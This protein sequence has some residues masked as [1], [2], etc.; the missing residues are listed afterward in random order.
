M[1]IVKPMDVLSS[2]MPSSA[3][4]LGHLVH[5]PSLPVAV[6]LPQAVCHTLELSPSLLLFCEFQAAIA[7]G[8][9]LSAEVACCVIEDADACVSHADRQRDQA[10]ARKMYAPSSTSATPRPPSRVMDD[11][12]DEGIT[13]SHL[14][15][16]HYRAPEMQAP[17]MVD[18]QNSQ[19]HLPSTVSNGFAKASAEPSAS[20]PM[21]TR[22]YAE[23]GTGVQ[24]CQFYREDMSLRT[25]MRL[26]IP[27]PSSSTMARSIC[28]GS[29]WYA[30][31]IPYPHEVESYDELDGKKHTDANAR[32][33]PGNM[34]SIDPAAIHFLQ[35]PKSSKTECSDTDSKPESS[36][37][38]QS[39]PSTKTAFQGLPNTIQPP[40]IHLQEVYQ[41][42]MHSK[43][44]G[45]LRTTSNATSVP[46]NNDNFADLFAYRFAEQQSSTVPFDYSIIT[47][48]F[49]QL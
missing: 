37:P 35:E 2:A 11:D 38:S 18:S 29:V 19:M 41:Y 48:L 24:R 26:I 16:L 27:Q 12:Y 46:D 32:L 13:E 22:T 25:R 28:I 6:F 14:T 21:P 8:A 39:S 3:T 47:L 17:S 36:D 45:K 7:N 43:S 9:P 5:L 10:E 49:H 42:A 30:F 40:P 1:L 34:I 15:L 23:T 44:A 33:A 31:T 4:P 20:P